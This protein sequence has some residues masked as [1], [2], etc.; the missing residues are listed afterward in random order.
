MA[1]LASREG[2]RVTGVSTTVWTDALS[3]RIQS[4]QGYKHV[5]PSGWTNGRPNYRER[6]EATENPGY[7][8]LRGRKGNLT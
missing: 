8:R 4:G 7:V 1:S 6:G 2:N 5:R 3:D